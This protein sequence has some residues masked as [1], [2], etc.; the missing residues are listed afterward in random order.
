[1]ILESKL[2]LLTKVTRCKCSVLLNRNRYCI[3]RYEIKIS[4]I[5]IFYGE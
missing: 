2:N 5:T 4:D 3:T 1:M